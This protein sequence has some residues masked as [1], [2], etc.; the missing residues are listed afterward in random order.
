IDATCGAAREGATGGVW[1]PI[2]RPVANTR[3]YVVGRWGELAPEGAAG[4][5]Y[6]GGAQVARGY[7]NRPGLTAERFVPDPYGGEPGARLYRTGDVVRYLAGGV[8]DFV[9]RCDQQV[10]L[11]GHRVEL[12]EVEAALCEHPRVRECAAAVTGEGERR[13]LVAYV[14]ARGEGGE[15][16]RRNGG[17]AGGGGPDA[18]ELRRFLS[19]RLPGQ[20]VPSQFVTLDALPL[21]PNGK[22]DRR[23]L[24][25]P[26]EL[27]RGESLVMA[28]NAVE[29]RL[30][31]VWEEVLGVR[32]V[33]IKDD[34]F[35]SGGHSLLAVRLVTRIEQAFGKQLPLSVLY[36]GATVEDMA[37]LLGREAGAGR[38]SLVRL[39]EGGPA[40]PFCC[41][42]P[43]GGN[44]FCYVE[45]A[46]RFGTERPF[47]GLQARGLDG[48]APHTRVEEMAAHYVGE[49]RA[50]QPE[51]PYLLGGWSFGGVVAFEMARQ[52]R[53]RGQRVSLLA[54]LDS[55][56]PRPAADGRGDEAARLLS[57]AR[58]VGLSPE[59]LHVSRERIERLDRDERLGH[60][61]ELAKAADL[62]PPDIE[63]AHVSRLW[64]VF[65]AN[66]VAARDYVP[67]PYAGRVTLVRAGANAAGRDQ[68]GE[69][70]PLAR[71]GLE[72]LTVPGDH[73]SFVREPHAG[74]LA[75][76]L[77]ACLERAREV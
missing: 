7:W 51:G 19:G 53:E 10:K 17:E 28:R 2:G 75:E 50:V 32:P 73:F 8:L 3:C 43:A 49:L 39:Q 72:V 56:V 55:F 67:R 70:A 54:L 40:A 31:R 57:F 71:G 22:V 44:V 35:Q 64:E 59:R 4:E 20:M 60:V 76:A 6:V 58:H 5:L 52:L 27:G 14:V 47:Y 62:L 61:L 34:F 36:R 18:A 33:G 38:G 13:R 42:H 24:P 15:G 29:L 77:R 30:T 26:G 63:R 69:W 74:A 37:V 23:A 11:R 21:T 46:R 1:V 65:E 41:V 66:L 25:E 12:G 68:A 9:G 48:G 16:G 45:L